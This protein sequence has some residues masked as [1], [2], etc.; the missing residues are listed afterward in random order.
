ME[1]CATR[2]IGKT[3]FMMMDGGVAKMEESLLPPI[4]KSRLSYDVSGKYAKTRYALPFIPD[5]GT[6]KRNNI[7]PVLSYWRAR[8]RNSKKNLEHI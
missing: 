4:L 7:S 1:G 2:S 5:R 8:V 3:P 6:G